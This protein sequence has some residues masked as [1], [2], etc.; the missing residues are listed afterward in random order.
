VETVVEETIEVREVNFSNDS[1]A[2]SGDLIEISL[3]PDSSVRWNID[4][5]RGSGDLSAFE[6][7]LD[8]ELASSGVPDDTGVRVS[9]AAGVQTEG[10]VELLE[11]LSARGIDSITFSDG[12][13]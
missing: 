12:E 10:V 1:P 3:L 4:E 5:L 9:V 11:M 13:E 8:T 6:T 2:D 7:L